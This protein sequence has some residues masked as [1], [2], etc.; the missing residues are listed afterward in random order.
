MSKEQIDQEY[1]S[2]AAALE[3]ESFDIIEEFKNVQELVNS[4][5]KA[6]P[7]KVGQHRELKPDKSMDEFNQRHA[8]IWQNHEAELIAEGYLIPREPSRDLA[9]EVNQLETRLAALEAK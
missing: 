5:I 2:Q 8:Q 6:I 7:I 1:Q 4:K 3:E 9:F